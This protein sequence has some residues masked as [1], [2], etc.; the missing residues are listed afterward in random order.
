MGGACGMH[1]KEEKN[2]CRDF[3]GETW[4]DETAWDEGVE[5]CEDNI[6]SDLR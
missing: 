4:R 1:D 6:K 5:R 3:G 2:A